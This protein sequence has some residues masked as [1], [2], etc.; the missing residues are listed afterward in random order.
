M[1]MERHG[2]FSIVILFA[3][4]PLPHDVIG[5][6]CG[7]INYNIKKFF[8]ATLIGKVIM[9]LFIAWGGFLGVNWVLTV[10]GG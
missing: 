7:V 4:T 1:W 8:L 5:I 2:A 9:N 3:M 10:F 6:L